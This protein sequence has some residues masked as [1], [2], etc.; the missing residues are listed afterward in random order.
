MAL[1][2]RWI[3]IETTTHCNSH[4]TVCP[5]GTLFQHPLT[6]M[7]EALFSKILREIAEEH[8]V[9]EHIRFGGMGDPSCDNQL[10]ERLRFMQKETAH[11]SP[12]VASNMASWKKRY[13]EAVIQEQLLPAMRFSLLGL[14]PERS[15]RAYQRAEQGEQA[16]RAIDYFLEYN[17]RS[18]QPVRTELYTLLMPDD[19][20]EVAH[21]KEVFWDRV[22]AFEVWRPHSWSNLFPQLRPTQN[23]R[24]QCS[25]LLQPEPV[26]CVN[27]DVCPCS[28]DVNRQLAF[29]NV[30]EQS[31]QE[32]YQGAAW[33]R[34]VALNAQGL[35]ET[36]PT[37]H[38][39]TFL[40]ADGSGVLIEHK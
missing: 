36:L 31:L 18:S 32:I 30:G 37:C 7:S 39:C 2:F 22:D 12:H 10:L 13:T 17:S 16:R 19:Q 1:R 34:L 28:M 20:G 24:R 23:E 26:I 40:N 33:Q 4:C 35:I 9:D 25:K 6:T 27:G 14:S 3:A 21:I 38:G 5:H 8:T 29:G 11:L 15:M